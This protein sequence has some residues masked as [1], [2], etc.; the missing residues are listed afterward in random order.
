MPLARADEQSLQE[1]IQ[2]QAKELMRKSDLPNLDRIAAG[3]RETR[4]TTPAGFSKLSLF[5]N[6]LERI[7][8]DGRDKAWGAAL[9]DSEIWLKNHPRSPSAVIIN[10]KLLVKYAWARRGN[11]MADQVTKWNARHFEDLVEQARQVLDDNK[12]VGQLDPEW[13][14]LRISVA[15]WQG[16]NR[17]EI[18]KQ[19]TLAAQLEPYYDPIHYA[20]VYAM[21]PKWGGTT[22]LVKQ[23]VNIATA[24]TSAKLGKQMYGR[25]YLYVAR[26]AGSYVSSEFAAAGE[27]WLHL[28][29]SM[30]EI[31]SAYPDAWNAN[32]YRV[33]A[34]AAGTKDDYRKAMVDINQ[35]Y[36]GKLIEYLDI[37]TP[38]WQQRCLKWSAA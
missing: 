4:E 31:M 10:A 33:V 15:N 12:T 19:A 27:D 14:A 18:L 38:E 23:Y 37:D 7:G 8:V 26:R 13:Y 2:D 28:N 3:Y 30:S 29:A 17:Y 22:E 35:R 32:A 20:A 25:I 24:L 1:A 9:D 11:G 34:C 21:L 16:V 36:G 5:Y 6:G